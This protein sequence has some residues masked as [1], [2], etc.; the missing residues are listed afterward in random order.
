MKKYLFLLIAIFAISCTSKDEE[1]VHE[2]MFH[3]VATN[4]SYELTLTPKMASSDDITDVWN[5]LYK[6]RNTLL[7]FAKN[8]N[9]VKIANQFKVM[10]IL[11]KNT[12]EAS[13]KMDF[14][15]LLL[16]TKNA[17]EE[18]TELLKSNYIFLENKYKKRMKEKVLELY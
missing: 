9:E 1:F 7:I 18:Y 4:Y 15:R 17:R 14:N 5:K 13:N 12:F 10:A 6:D 2:W 16:K 11:I 3:E 8:D